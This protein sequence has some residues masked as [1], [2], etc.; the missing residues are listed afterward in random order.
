MNSSRHTTFVKLYLKFQ[1]IFNLTPTPYSIGIFLKKKKKNVVQK[2]KIN[3]N[4]TVHKNPM[5]VS[6]L[7]Q[8]NPIGILFPYIYIYSVYALDRGYSL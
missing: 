6:L 5:P 1:L 8:I 2:I 7:S 4:I 3:V